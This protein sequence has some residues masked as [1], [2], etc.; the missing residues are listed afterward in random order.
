[1]TRKTGIV[2]WFDE[3]KGFGFISPDGSEEDVFVHWSAL[4][5]ENGWRMPIDAQDRVEFAI[6]AGLKGPRAVDIA[7]A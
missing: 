1:M 2:K 6:E 7:V 3:E 5:T 4:P